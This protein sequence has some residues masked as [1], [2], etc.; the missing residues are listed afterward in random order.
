[1]MFIR[2]F[3]L[4]F[5]LALCV[6]QPMVALASDLI[7]KGNLIE[8]PCIIDPGSSSQV[9]QFMETSTRLYQSMPGKSYAEKFEIRLINCNALALGKIVDVVFTGTEEPSL[10]GYLKVN[11]INE[12]KLAIGIMDNLENNLL[13]INQNNNNSG[14]VIEGDNVNMTYKAFVQATPKAIID[15]TVRPGNYSSI[16]TFNISYK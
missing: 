5:Y 14:K 16:L 7:L 13:K 10:P 4:Y 8:S 3:N 11:G 12:G 15:K 1:M 6:T 2:Y 9:I